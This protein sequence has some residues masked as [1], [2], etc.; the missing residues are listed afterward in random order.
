MP[1]RCRD[2]I[3]DLK[4]QEVKD[5]TESDTHVYGFEI[6]SEAGKWYQPKVCI[7]GDRLIIKEKEKVTGVRYGFFN[8]GK[9][10]LYNSKGLPL[11]QF[12]YHGDV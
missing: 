8:Y 10:N 12:S 6:C 9:V 11:K 2:T 7:E 5:E 1:E 4:E 3:S